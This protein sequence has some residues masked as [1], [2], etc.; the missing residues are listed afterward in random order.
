MSKPIITFEASVT[1]TAKPQAIYD[2]LSDPTTHLQWAG[3]QSPDKSFR[4]LDLDADGPLT[5][6]SRFSSSGTSLGSQ[7]F[8]DRSVVTEA[9]APSVLAFET[10]SHL[11]R[12]HRPDWEAKFVHR[13][14]V[15]SDGDGS[16]ID[17]I[18]DVY[19]Q[20]YRP[21]WLHPLFRPVMRVGVPRSITKNMENLVRIAEAK[22]AAA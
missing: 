13:Y 22:K 11:D 10:A 17:Y 16:R 15:T 5:P 2:V 21:F 12:P 9:T 3:E 14:T 20:N 6:G 18:C 8:H 19:P 4:L 1:S 7:I